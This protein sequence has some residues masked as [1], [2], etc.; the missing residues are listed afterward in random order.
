MK[1]AAMIKPIIA[2]LIFV[3]LTFLFLLAAIPGY[4][5]TLDGPNL[6]AAPNT[7]H[8]VSSSKTEEDRSNAPSAAATCLSWTHLAKVPTGGF[9]QG[10]ATSD[11]KFAY[12]AGG[13]STSGATNYFN[14]FDPVNGAWTSLATMPAGSTYP[15]A[16]YSPINHKVYVFGGVINM[17]SV[18]NTRVY[19]IVTNQWSAG[20]AMPAPRDSMAATYYNGRIYLV[21]GKVGATANRSFG[22]TILWLTIGTRHGLPFH[23]QS[24]T[25]ASG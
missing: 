6:S 19:D 11:G 14:R 7:S 21:G 15:S 16:V 9:F 2:N 13:F 20:T 18:T 4:S 22:N 17:A 24:L 10:A 12:V 5:H 23:N 8:S 3:R 1:L 25:L